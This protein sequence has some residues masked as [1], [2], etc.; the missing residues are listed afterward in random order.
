MVSD[1]VILNPGASPAG[2][3]LHLYRMVNCCFWD[4]G[5][6]GG[7]AHP[8][9]QLSFSSDLDHLVFAKSWDCRIRKR[10]GSSALVD[11]QFSK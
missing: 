3:T 6:P 5:V 7:R 10:G 2:S 1:Q 4:A 8:A 11:W 9:C